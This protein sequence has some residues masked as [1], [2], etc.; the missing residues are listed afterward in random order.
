MYL[1]LSNPIARIASK[2]GTVRRIVENLDFQKQRTSILPMKRLPRPLSST[3]EI[4][5]KPLKALID[6]GS[7]VYT[8]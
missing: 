7:A 3:V 5:G 6:A 2:R 1:T 8:M 4:S